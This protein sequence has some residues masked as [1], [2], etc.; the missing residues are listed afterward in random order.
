M[1]KVGS[2]AFSLL[3]HVRT[4]LPALLMHGHLGMP[5]GDAFYCALVVKI[6]VAQIM[7][8]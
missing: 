6:F 4:C 7:Y 8:T 3:L 1:L 2:P 5:A